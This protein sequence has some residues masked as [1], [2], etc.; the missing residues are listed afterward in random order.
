MLTAQLPVPLQPV[1]EQ[2]LAGFHNLQRL[3]GDILVA[4]GLVVAVDLLQLLVEYGR[5]DGQ[6][7]WFLREL[8]EPL[9]TA[10][11]LIKCLVL[12]EMMNLYGF[13]CVNFTVSPI[14]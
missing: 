7:G 8:N 4:L 14:I 11:C 5:K 12:P 2:T 9:M 10:F 6:I 1:V 3:Q 13:F